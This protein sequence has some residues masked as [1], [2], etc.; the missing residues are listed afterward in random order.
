MR[1]IF[2][3]PAVALLVA[4]LASVVIL[5]ACY[6]LLVGPRKGAIDKKQKEVEAVDQKIQ[7][8][9]ATYK[10][11]LNIKN[12]S[13]EYEAKLAYLQSIIPQEPE[14]PSLIRNLQAA[15]DP[16]SGAGLPWLSFSPGE[17]GAGEGGATYSSYT[18]SMTV[19]GFYDEV[20]D[21]IYRMERFP[22]AVV[23]NSVNITASTGFLQR[24]FSPNIGV[25][26]AELTAKTFTFA[27]P[28]GAAAPA[29]PATTP[30]P[31]SQPSSSAPGATP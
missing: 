5:A 12:R 27:A 20:V 15:A 21:L 26:Q 22:R 2:K 10:E 19:G 24:T 4:V 3:R 18:F 16:G 17:V 30:A 6:F 23:I 13:A 11:L 29:A 31:Q 8:E 28:A 1:K 9:K 25:V 7:A 14:L